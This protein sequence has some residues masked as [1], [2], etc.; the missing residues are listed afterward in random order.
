MILTIKLS[1]T[2]KKFLD[3]YHPRIIKGEPHDE[4]GWMML[5]IL[6]NSDNR[7]KY[8][9]LFEQN[10]IK[11]RSGNVHEK[12]DFS[13]EITIEIANWRLE[14]INRQK[15]DAQSMVEINTY[16]RKLLLRTFI[17]YMIVE[18]DVNKGFINDAIA[19]FQAFY[20]LCDD[21]LS[22]DTC[23]RFW[24]RHKNDASPHRNILHE[25]ITTRRR[26]VKS[27]GISP[28]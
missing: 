3:R 24:Q 14:H 12:Y 8:E 15:F 23:K 9:W 2:V 7:V 5:T 25:N 6:S 21:D 17:N 27:R 26:A 22:A 19:H 11:V 4:I 20:D 13:E 28:T 16:L 1:K 18:V 10:G